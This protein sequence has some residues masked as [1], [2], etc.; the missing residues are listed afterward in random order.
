MNRLP[1]YVAGVVFVVAVALPVLWSPRDDSFPLSTY[2]MFAGRKEREVT[3]D[4]VVGVASDGRRASL[5]PPAIANE[6]VVQA[7]ETIRQAIRLGPW[8]TQS[9]CQRAAIWARSHRPSVESVEIVSSRYDAIAYF[10][11]D[12]EPA[13]STLHTRCRVDGQ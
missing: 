9:L 7:L 6:E 1:G 8:A 5:P 10:Q 12:K 4:H 13:A 3:V 2:P 11:G